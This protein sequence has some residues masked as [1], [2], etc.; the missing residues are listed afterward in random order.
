MLLGQTDRQGRM[1]FV[2]YSKKSGDF[3]MGVFALQRSCFSPRK[4]AVGQ[5]IS[6]CQ[7]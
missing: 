6:V 4:R 3:C 2:H 1:F 5:L 7:I